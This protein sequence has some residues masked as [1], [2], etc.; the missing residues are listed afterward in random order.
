MGAPQGSIQQKPKIWSRDFTFIVIA[1]FFIFTGFQMTLPTL[2]LF[3]EHLGGNNQLIGLVVGIFTLSSLSIRPWV[4]HALESRGRRLIFLTGL[5]I[6]VISVGSYV[7]IG[8]IV[9]LFIMR[10]VQGVGWGMSTTAAGTVATDLIPPKRRGEGM[11]YFG[12]SG[13]LALAVGPSLGLLLVSVILFSKTFLIASLCGLAALI[14][15]TFIVYKPVDKTMK[16][17]PSVKKKFDIYEPSAIKPASLMFFITMCFGGIASF[18]PIYAKQKGIEGIDWYFFIYAMAL[19]VSRSFSGRIYDRKG[20]K[21]IFIPGA[22]FVIAAMLNLAYLGSFLNLAI[23]AVLFGIGFG[24]IQPA[25]QAW[26][27][28]SAPPQR[29]GMANATFFSFFD[30][31]VGF[32]AV[33]FGAVA[34][35]LSYRY[36]YIFAAISVVISIFIYLIYVKRENN[37]GKR[38]PAPVRV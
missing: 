9:L 22:L 36:I 13:N 10:I 32:G 26:A 34:S 18:L 19:L 4:G 33:F 25:M 2:P 17:Q 31:G 16:E 7:F 6:F 8:G 28:D 30:L 35:M 24:S 3:V 27:V 38:K 37:E 20:H 12:L 1:N 5:I 11:G 21:A 14:I 29:K 23:G 15:A